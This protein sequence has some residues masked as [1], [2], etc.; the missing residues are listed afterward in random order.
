MRAAPL[1]ALLALG[2]A[3]SRGEGPEAAYRAFVRAVAERD[4]DGAFALLSVGSR[5]RLDERARAAARS[6]PGVVAPS[7]AQLLLGDAS[8]G[9]RRVVAI[10]VASESG[11]RA[12][13]RVETEGAASAEVTLVREGG[14]RVELPPE[15]R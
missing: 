2:F 1:A 15:P 14:W 3:C 12:V 4:A 13:L 8:R 7:G 5:R 10:S 11:D 9:A 6:A